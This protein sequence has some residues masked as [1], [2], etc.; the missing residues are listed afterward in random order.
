MTPNIG[1]VEGGTTVT[2]E[3]SGFTEETR[4]RIGPLVLEQVVLDS[5]EQV[6]AVTPAGSLGWNPV[7]ATDDSGI[8]EQEAIL[9]QG[10]RYTT[11]PEVISFSPTSGSVAGGTLITIRGR[12]FQGQPTVTL[13]N[14]PCVDVQLLDQ[15]SITCRT[16]PGREG[17]VEVQ[18]QMEGRAM[19]APERFTYFNPTSRFGGAWGDDINGSVN[20]SVY[21]VGGSPIENAFVMLSVDANTPYQG[22]T[23]ANGQVTFSGD[24]VFGEQ[25]VTATAAEH[26][27]AS[28]QAVDA[29]NITIL[30]YPVTPP[31]GGGG[32]SLP[33]ATITGRVDGFQK[34]RE[35]LPHERQIVIVETTRESP[36]RGN[37]NPGGGNVVSADG[38]GTY[39]LTS[40]IGDLAVVAIGGLVDTRNGDFTPYVMGIARYLFVTQNELVELDLELNIDLDYEMRIKVNGASLSEEGP[41]NNRVTP[42]VDLGFEGV[43][44]GWDEAQGESNIIVAA[45][46]PPLAGELADATFFLYGGS[47]T[48]QASSPYAVAQLGELGAP[49]PP[50][51]EMPTLVAIPRPEFPSDG[52]IVQDRYVSF[53]PSTIHPPDFWRVQIY[54]L[55]STLVWEVTLPG[56][57]NW[58]QLPQFPDFS[59]VPFEDQPR[60]YGFNGPLYM[61]VSGAR[62][63]DFDFDNHEYLNDLRRRD[64]WTSWSRNAWYILLTD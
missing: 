48:N 22:W 16:P 62:I 10:F 57:Q 11:E 25:Y 20:I 9:E 64:R 26:S 31:S 36:W 42:W 55:P 8:I 3:G 61:V 32:G 56:S 15:A 60:P 53:A 54:L 27:S 30:L 50:L 5:S 28:V 49:L 38:D 29:E 51:I 13:D 2:I 1:P 47:W 21:S 37:P 41:T 40:R 19:T 39:T 63:P 45:H 4:F 35:P 33:L 34:I 52:G 24:L 43:F 46:Q 6:R 14:A 23:D 17:T 58:F 44:G 7:R 18:V 12:G 59:E